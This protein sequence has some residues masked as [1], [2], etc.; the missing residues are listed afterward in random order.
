MRCLSLTKLV[1]AGDLMFRTALI[2]TLEEVVVG[3]T[4]VGGRADGADKIAVVVSEGVVVLA[5]GVVVGAADVT[6][7]VNEGVTDVVRPEV[8]VVAL[9]TWGPRVVRDEGEEGFAT[10]ETEVAV[11]VAVEGEVEA[12]VREEETG[13]VREEVTVGITIDL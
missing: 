5:R 2:E 7:A 4:G 6:V 8:T 13:A 11:E 10:E 12:I 9:A 1:A 3:A